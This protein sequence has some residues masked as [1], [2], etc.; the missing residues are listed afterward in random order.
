MTSHEQEAEVADI[1]LATEQEAQSQEG[2]QLQPPQEGQRPNPPL[3]KLT[4]AAAAA[5]SSGVPREQQSPS[6]K[7]ETSTAGAGEAPSHE[8]SAVAVAAVAVAMPA[9]QQQ[10]AGELKQLM[11]SVGEA[12]GV[13]GCHA[14]RKVVH[15]GSRITYILLYSL[16]CTYTAPLFVTRAACVTAVFCWIRRTAGP[17]QQESSEN[18]PAPNALITARWFW[19]R[20]MGI[21]TYVALFSSFRRH[22]S[23]QQQ[24]AEKARALSKNHPR[25][26][27][28]Q[29][30]RTSSLTVVF[31]T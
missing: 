26:L 8:A 17:A 29:G 9:Q 6:S 4:T 14:T 21:H 16:D 24:Q 31:F 1:R 20:Y 25:T 28:F 3:Q 22:G 11:G 7:E 18:I 27:R 13:S 23:A 5:A 10:G 12:M 30:C 2:L 19:R 15:F